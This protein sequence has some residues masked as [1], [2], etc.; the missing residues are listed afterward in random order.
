MARSDLVVTAPNALG[1]LAPAGLGVVAVECPLP[2]PRHS[3]NLVWHERFG[4]DPAH[5]WLRQQVIDMA[6]E[7]QRDI[8]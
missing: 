5:A 1:Y 2:L 6:S 3:V 7:L 8:G 4:K